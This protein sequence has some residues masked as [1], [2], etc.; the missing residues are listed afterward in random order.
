[1]TTRGSPESG[2][3]YQPFRQYLKPLNTVTHVMATKQTYEK[4]RMHHANIAVNSKN[5][6]FPKDNCS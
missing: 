3:K 2:Q 5:Y 1:M 6:S 4:V